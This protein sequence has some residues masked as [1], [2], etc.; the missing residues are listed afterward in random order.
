LEGGLLRF[1]WNEWSQLGVLGHVGRA[2]PWAADLEALLVMS[3]EVARADPRLFDEVLDWL[4]VNEQL[5]SVRRLR[6]LARTSPEPSLAAAVLTWLAQHRPKARFSGT[7]DPPAPTGQRRLFFDEGFPIRRLDEAF[8]RHGWERPAA[9]PSAKSSTPDLRVPIAFG[10]RMRRLLG[11]GVR[12]EVARYLL[13]T[14]APR[15][16][17]AVVTR[18]AAFTKRNVQEALSELQDAGAVQASR[19]GHEWRYG[20]DRDGWAALLALDGF[21]AAVD[22]V[23]LLGAAT[24]ILAWLRIGALPDTTEYLQASAARTLLEE[25]R[26]DLEYAGILVGAGR[27][28]DALGDLD[29]VVNRIL[30]ELRVAVA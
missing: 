18:S 14:D 29:A 2:S 17:A 6:T 22:W 23:P 13:T 20:I 27:G 1:A 19:V 15:S 26:A 7:Q 5:M 28:A 12:A 11:T 24:R 8:A 10:L 25:V 21:P 9:H 4:V 30:G 16:T 3:L